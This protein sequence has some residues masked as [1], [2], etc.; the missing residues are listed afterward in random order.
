M[1]LSD[2]PENSWGIIGKDIVVKLNE[3]FMFPLITTKLLIAI[4]GEKTP[5]GLHKIFPTPSDMRHESP[6]RELDAVLQIS[7]IM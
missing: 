2:L 7:T 6:N 1:H 4:V 3:K 5:E